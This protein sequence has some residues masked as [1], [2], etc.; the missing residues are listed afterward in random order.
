MDRRRV[1]RYEILEC[2]VF[3]FYSKTNNGRNRGQ[4][5]MNVLC[6]CEGGRGR[7]EDLDTMTTSS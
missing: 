1:K 3:F 4:L 6:V 2:T 5:S 7:V